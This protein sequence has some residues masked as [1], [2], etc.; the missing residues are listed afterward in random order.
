MVEDNFDRDSSVE[1][2][3]IEEPERQLKPSRKHLTYLFVGGA[4]LLGSLTLFVMARKLIRLA[5]FS[6]PHVSVSGMRDSS[7]LRAESVQAFSEFDASSDP[8]AEL[9][10]EERQAIVELFEKIELCAQEEDNDRFSE[11]VDHNRLLKRMELTGRLAAYSNLEKRFLRAELKNAFEID[12]NWSQLQIVEVLTLKDDPSSR[13]VYAYS[14]S[15]SSEERNENRFLIASDGDA[16]KLYDWERMDLGI[17]ASEEWSLYAQYANTSLMAGYSRWG[18]L[19]GEADEAMLEGD[20]ETAKSKI[21]LAEQQSAP[22]ELGGYLWVI[23][24]YRWHIL[25]ETAEATRCFLNV[26]HPEE[27]PGAYFGLMNCNRWRDYETALKYAD[28][29]EKT[30]GPSPELCQIKARMLEENGRKELA[31]VEWKKLLRTE[32]ENEAAL[33]TL[34]LSHRKDDKSTFEPYLTRLT[35]PS[36]TIASIATF[37]GW[38]DYQGLLYLA[39]YLKNQ[40]PNSPA[41]NYVLGVAQSL[42]G[43]HQE[44]AGHY[45]LAYLSEKDED[46]ISKYANAYVEAMSE[47]G[48]GVAAWKQVPDPES[49]FDSIAYDYE[50][51]VSLLSTQEFRELV[52]AYCERFPNALDGFYQR[53]LIAIEENRYEE[54]EGILRAGLKSAETEVEADSDKDGKEEQDEDE[55]ERD[56]LTYSLGQVLYRL[57]R[58]REAYEDA[59]DKKQQFSQLCRIAVFDRRWDEVQML[60]KLHH[61]QEPDDSRLNYYA[62]ELAAEE[63]LWDEAFKELEEGIEKESDDNSWIFENRLKELSIESNR[64]LQYYTSSSKP[65]EA[66]DSLANSFSLKEDWTSLDRLIAEHQKNWALDLQIIKYK[67]NAS[68]QIKN[69][70]A[71]IQLAKSL[72]E[73]KDNE[74]ISFYQKSAFEDRLLRALLRSGQPEEALEL[75]KKYQQR[76]NDPSKLAIVYAMTGKYTQAEHLAGLVAAQNDGAEAFY[77]HDE[78]GPIFLSS[79]F[80]LLQ[81][82]YPVALSYDSPANS[83]IFISEEPWQLDVASISNTLREIDRSDVLSV[84]PLKSIRG[85]VENAFSVRL[86]NGSLWIATGAGK[87][88]LDWSFDAD[89]APLAATANNCPYWLAVGISAL[90]EPRHEQM[91]DPFRHLA[92]QLAGGKPKAFYVVEDWSWKVFLAKENIL[93]AWQSSMNLKPFQNDRLSVQVSSRNRNLVTDREFEREL[94][95]AV[96][97]FEASPGTRLEVLTCLSKGAEVDP[98]R[99]DVRSVKRTYGKLRFEGPLI[100]SSVLIPELRAGLNVRFGYHEIRAWR[101]NSERT[102]IRAQSH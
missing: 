16:W 88:D 98:L 14:S 75:A 92:I 78:A 101:L 20:N 67:A 1:W 43:N 30:V 6:V 4:F 37:V 49:A 39:N 9:S 99:M 91:N 17:F 52:A 50:E 85:D 57:G 40:A 38:Q 28:M 22:R 93:S 76:D 63:E 21:R 12:L 5:Q 64:W 79:R 95:Q 23:A 29:Y 42:D 48:Q 54:A 97:T 77:S 62:A 47:L 24:G 71:Y 10:P 53:S 80:R 56:T 70:P 18:E 31:L 68:W 41:S 74:V 32:P 66:F 89:S 86:E 65:K 19:L 2:L 82:K 51:E 25:G 7:E 44:A 87:F 84:T 13:V 3:S 15:A 58:A 11:I 73:S 100:A 83:V 45:R 36:A 26:D 8:F 33:K 60:L 81:E 55:Y 72:L 34:L 69:Y 61:A 27:V 96:R 35:N 59:G 46:A 94:R 102:V 90:T